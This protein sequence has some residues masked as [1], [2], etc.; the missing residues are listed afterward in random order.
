MTTA[1]IRV[2]VHAGFHKTGTT[3]LQDFLYQNKSSLAPYMA[4]YGKMDFL[5]AG[6]QAR[7]Y[8]Q[9]PFPHR[10]IKFRY[11]FRA[12]LENIPDHSMIVLSRETFSGGMP[13][14]HTLSGRL[15]TSYQR[16]AKRLAKVDYLR[17]ATPFRPKRRNH[18]LLYNSGTRK[19]ATFCIWSPAPF[20]PHHR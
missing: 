20:N 12:F 3:S 7:I 8:A 19:L 2:I 13:G 18:V 11:A 10:L 17:T 4:Y 1:P 9:R 6:T 16:P 15:M 14:H 5:D